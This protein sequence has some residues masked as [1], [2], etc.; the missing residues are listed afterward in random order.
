MLKYLSKI[1]LQSVTFFSFIFLQ[2]I[3]IYFGN[4]E[5]TDKSISIYYY[6]NIIIFTASYIIV[7]N[8]FLYIDFDFPKRFFSNNFIDLKLI[9]KLFL[10]LSFVNVYIGIFD[11]N[12]KF[13]K[14]FYLFQYVIPA[15][16]FLL[17]K[18]YKTNIFLITLIIIFILI[19]AYLFNTKS[20][21]FYTMFILFCFI[22]YRIIILKKINYKLI[23]FLLLILISCITIIFL[24]YFKIYALD[25]S[26]L[27]NYKFTIERIFGRISHV[28]VSNLAYSQSN[29]DIDISNYIKIV[30]YSILPINFF[31]ENQEIYN[32][33]YYLKNNIYAFDFLNL[34]NSYKHTFSI[35]F[36]SDSYLIFEMQFLIFFYIFC[37]SL[38]KIL[39]KI[40]N[41]NFN[42]L[43]LIFIISL[44]SN[45]ILAFNYF[46]RSVIL[47]LLFLLIIIFLRKFLKIKRS[48]FSNNI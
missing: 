25:F 48:N 10:L 8:I 42:I 4:T 35:N 19:N 24:L 9:L 12:F 47:I 45:I 31:L 15:F 34:K 40:L 46:I 33:I 11:I 18:E 44:D 43:F 22:I 37:F 16:L 32:A 6:V 26:S 20:N 14:Y 29:F 39:E 17:L 23:I 41:D 27:E 28:E 2:L 3:S 21:A 13:L 38:L 1:D 7:K 36:I 30:I 5:L